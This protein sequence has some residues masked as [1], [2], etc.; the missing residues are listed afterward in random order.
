MPDAFHRVEAAIQAHID[1]SRNHDSLGDAAIE[2]LL[3]GPCRELTA[4]HPATPRR[5][6]RSPNAS[7]T[8]DQGD[9]MT[10][11][12]LRVEALAGPWQAILPTPT[13]SSMASLTALLCGLPDAGENPAT[14]WAAAGHVG[15]D[16]GRMQPVEQH[17]G[18]SQRRR[19]WEVAVPVLLVSGGWI[20]VAGV[21]LFGVWLGSLWFIWFLYGLVY[22]LACLIAV[23]LSALGVTALWRFRGPRWA[24]PV[25]VC[26]VLTPIAMFMVSL[27]LLPLP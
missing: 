3:T 26:S 4:E 9:L 2:T 19:W 27:A 24:V 23:A 17:S 13:A 15:L 8:A 7:A 5:S 25:L 14:E 11:D 6:R 20:L 22:A 21:H 16:D 1:G 12:E 10:T 18:R